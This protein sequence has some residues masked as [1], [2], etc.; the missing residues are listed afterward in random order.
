MLFSVFTLDNPDAAD[1]RKAIHSDHV[2]HLRSAK[3]Y[4]VA[5]TVGGPLVSD[6]GV[7]PIG[8]L[9][10][11]EAPDRATAEKFNRADPFHKN[12]VWG[13]VEIRRFDRRE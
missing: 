12:G 3:D 2:A 7:S 1:K 13:K 6:D 4:G 9:M 11:L 5:I 8:S 10:V